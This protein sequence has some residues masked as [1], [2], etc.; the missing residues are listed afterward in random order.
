MTAHAQS[1][2]CEWA[3]NDVILDIQKG[4]FFLGGG[5]LLGDSSS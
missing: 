2:N 5:G 4:F 3:A 1:M